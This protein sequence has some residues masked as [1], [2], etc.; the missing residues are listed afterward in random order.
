MATLNMVF[1]PR[2][3]FK[4]LQRHLNKVDGAYAEWGIY[5][6]SGLHPEA[7][8]PMPHLMAIHELRKDKWRRPVFALSA[9]RYEEDYLKQV[10]R[11]LRK[12]IMGSAAGVHKSLD[13]ALKDTANLGKKKAE[14]IFGNK[15]MLVPNSAATV[16]KKGH[17][18]PLIDMGILSKAVKAKVK[19]KGED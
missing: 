3:G 10:A 11:D 17:N 18:S 13:D 5:R 15:Q 14:G 4:N 19:K 7:K 1:K 2:P 12:Y 6:E 8:M 9:T 16:A